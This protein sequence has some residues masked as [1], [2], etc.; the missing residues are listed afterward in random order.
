MNKLDLRKELKHLYA[1]S[2]GKVEVV[3]VPEFQFAMI[4]GRI[5]PG[6]EPGTS[7]AFQE[8][9]E[10]LYGISYT[11]KFMSKL[12]AESPIDYTVMALEG[13]W[14]TAAGEFDF[15][16]K[17][18]W[19]WTA[20]ILQP[21]HI[22]PAMFQEGLGQLR[23]KRGDRPALGQL[24]LER[25]HEGLAMQIMHLGPY[26]EEPRTIE[27][28]MAFAQENGY[29]LRG[30]HHEIYLGDPRRTRPEKLKTILRHPI[31]RAA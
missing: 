10:A 21:D 28:M 19:Q 18:K 27:R 15:D 7:P 12:R 16:R 24:R 29:R 4:D 30:R 13:L 23:R 5:E 6:K 1:P 2:P 22:T 25:F 14:W 20:M 8:A 9:L 31:E 26:A 11:L 17:D 3:E